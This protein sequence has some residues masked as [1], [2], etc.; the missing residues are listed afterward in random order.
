MICELNVV[1]LLPNNTKKTKSAMPKKIH[2]GIPFQYPVC[3]HSDC[4]Q[5]ATCLHQIVYPKLLKSQTHLR[6]I[7]PQMCTKDRQCQFYRDSQPV[8]YARGFTNFQKKMYPGQYDKFMR[9]LIATFS[10]NSYY[11]RR[12]GDTLLSPIEQKTVLAALRK[13]GITENFDFD[14][15]EEHINLSCTEIG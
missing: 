6:L 13:V 9:L 5:A 15:Y 8:K 11:E 7:N 12:R 10:R 14:Q 2:L 3:Q 1:S 4:P